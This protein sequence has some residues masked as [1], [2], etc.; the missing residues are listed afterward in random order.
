MEV[1][2]VALT[3]VTLAELGDKTQFIALTMSARHQ[4]PLWVLG[5]AM[6]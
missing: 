2:F 1:C 3:A 5:S 4:K 6:L